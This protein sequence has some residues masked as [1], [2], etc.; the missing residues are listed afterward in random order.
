MISVLLVAAAAALLFGVD[1]AKLMAAVEW[2]KAHADAKRLAALGLVVL[3]VLLM[4]P[5]APHDEAPTP[6]PDAGPLSLRGSFV[7]PTASEDAALI[8]CLC[9]ELA[10]EIEFDGTQP[11]PFL[12][13]GQEVDELRK[14]ARVLR[15]R[16]ISIGDRQPKARD[17]IASYLEQTVGTDGG[18]LTAEQRAKWITAFH[19]IGR[20]ANDAAK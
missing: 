9:D 19:D 17:V 10:E 11:H 20:A 7:G 16:G 12:A 15:C 4:I 18:P 8:G 5:H 1:N 3:A 13:T 14:T 6:A 2:V